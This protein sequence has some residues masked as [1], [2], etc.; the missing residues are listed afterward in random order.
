MAIFAQLHALA[1]RQETAAEETLGL[2]EELGC[3]AEIE[4]GL[5][6]DDHEARALGWP[7][8]GAHAAVIRRV[9]ELL[10]PDVR[11][12]VVPRG[13]TLASAGAADARDA[14]ER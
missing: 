6:S 1:Q 11:V 8:V 9:W 13:S 2:W 5:A 12:I 10:P 3:P 7:C 4:I 14:T